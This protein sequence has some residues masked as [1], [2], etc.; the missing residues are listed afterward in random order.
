[1][2]ENL[3]HIVNGKSIHDS[4]APIEIFDPSNGKIISTI[5]N[6]SDKTIENTLKS[7][8]EAFNEWKNFSIAKRSSI[9]FE[10]KVLL[11]KNIQKLAEIISKDLGKVHDDAVGEIRRGIEN[12]EYACGIGEILKGEFNKNIS[13]SV[14]SWSEFSPLGPVLGITPFNFPAMVPLWMFPLAIAA[15]NSFI[16]KPSE[17]DPLGSM[18]I[19]ELFNQTKAPR[20]LLNLLNGDKSVVNKLIKDDRIKAVSFVGSTPVAKNIYETSAI[21][22]KRCQA[23]GGAKNHA[24]ILPDADIDYTTDQLISA[25]YGSSGQRCMALSV[26]VVFSDIKDEFI[27][28][29]ER[30]VQKLKFGLDDL[31]SNSFGPLVSKEHLESVKNYIDMSEE[32]GAR[33]LIDGRDFLKRKNSNN[34]Y[35]LGPTII[36]NVSS[37]MKSYQNEIFGPVLQII[38]V[39]KLSDAI[40]L[41]NNNKFGNGCCIFTRSGEQAKSFSENVEIGMVGV[42]IPLPVPT[43]FHSFGGWKNSLFGDLNI[44]GP[45]GVRFYTQRK[46]ITQRWPTSGSSKGVDLSMPN[47]LKQ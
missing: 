5:S 15:G 29:L 16:L 43:S 3:G 25:A 45:D 47:N 20:G 28:N 35:F 26:A 42:N 6:A 34:G 2:V 10:Y 40:K 4:G 33:V 12:V 24:L 7:S 46:T 18:F 31:H 38:E 30:K 41:I 37:N 21:S 11:E 23:L 17:K 19:V 32:E 44:Y 9:L 36:D 27:Q 13:T 8:T 14:D 39:S 1:M 22:G